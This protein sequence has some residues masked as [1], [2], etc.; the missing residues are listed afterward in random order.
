MGLK[1]EDACKSYFDATFEATNKCGPQK[2]IQG[3][4]VV[5]QLHYDGNGGQVTNAFSPSAGV[6]TVPCSGVYH[7][8]MS[9]RDGLTNKV[10]AIGTRNTG[11]TSNGWESL[12]TCTLQSFKGNEGQTLQMNLESEGGND[13]IEETGSHYTR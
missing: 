2:P 4:N 11:I 7:C 3:W 5:N 9:A 6:F 12:S 10:A 1:T 13:C 8:C